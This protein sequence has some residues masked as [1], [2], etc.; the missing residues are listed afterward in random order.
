M[1]AAPNQNLYAFGKPN[2][3]ARTEAYH[4]HALAPHDGITH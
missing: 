4:T 1:L 3:H 2:I